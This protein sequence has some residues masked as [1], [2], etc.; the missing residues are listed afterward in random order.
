MSADIY[1]ILFQR[2]EIG[3]CCGVGGKFHFDAFFEVFIRET[4][5]VGDMKFANSKLI[6][7]YRRRL[8][9]VARRHYHIIVDRVVD[10]HK[11]D[12]RRV[13]PYL[14]DVKLHHRHFRQIKCQ[15]DLIC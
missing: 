11:I 13:N 6:N 2:F 4:F 9:L 3:Y 8:A 7:D 5:V 1:V 10:F 15:L 12:A 14:F